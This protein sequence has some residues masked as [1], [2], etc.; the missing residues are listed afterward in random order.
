MGMRY[1]VVP[2]SDSQHEFMLHPA[3]ALRLGIDRQRKMS[4]RVG[5]HRYEMKLSTSRSLQ[6]NEIKLSQKWIKKLSLPLQPFYDMHVNENEIIL[7]PFIGLLAATT[8]D[9]L[10]KHL[11]GL[12]AYVKD[13][14]QIGGA[15][16]VFSL[17]GVKK[18][19]L[20]IDGYLYHP[21]TKRW[22]KGVYPYPAALFSI[23][24]VSMTKDWRLFRATM[25]HFRQIMGDRLFN[26]P[27]FN[28]WEAHQWLGRKPEFA[29][30]LPETIEYRKPDDVTRMLQKHQSVYL[31]PTWGRLGL[32]VMEVSLQNKGSLLIRFRKNRQNK[33]VLCK[34]FR[35]FTIFAKKHLK[36]RR[37]VIQQTVALLRKDGRIVDFRL[38]LLKNQHGEW[39]DAGLYSR[40][41]GK[42]SVIS[43]ISAGGNA[44]WG[45]ATLK[46]LL[47][48]T[49]AQA[50]QMRQKM[51]DLGLAI[52]DTLQME[53]IH[54]G[55]LGFDFAVDPMQRIWLLEINNQNP[56]P[57]IAR[58]AGKNE[59]F[60]YALKMNMLYAKRLAWGG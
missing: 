54:C 36:A 47:R 33:Q 35:E 37:Y 17:Q 18:E 53:G 50:D 21:G 13:Y 60:F 41:G 57:L 11:T 34:T 30:H 38:I 32:G 12:L 4:V 7:G 31:K 48:L 49:D 27:L 46:L 25:D 45:I 26:H 10:A 40:S 8:D 9:K 44:G 52:A 29:A 3:C 58:R 2:M 22:S 55:N 56:D 16:I 1:K 39:E 24:E 19:E 28:K 23:V 6:E 43:N 51:I 59:L 5:I 42:H 20:Q 15:I 14:R